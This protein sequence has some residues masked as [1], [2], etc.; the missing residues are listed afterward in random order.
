MLFEVSNIW[1]ICVF[2]LSSFKKIVIF[3]IIRSLKGT[4]IKTL[5]SDFL[6]EVT[7]LVQLYVVFDYS[8]T[9]ITSF[10]ELSSNGLQTLP[11]NIFNHVTLLRS[12]FVSLYSYHSFSSSLSRDI[13]DN[14]LISLPST[15]FSSLRNLNGLKVKWCCFY[16]QSFDSSKIC[17]PINFHPSLQRCLTIS[18]MLKLSLNITAFCLLRYFFIIDLSSN[19]LTQFP[20]GLVSKLNNLKYLFVLLCWSQRLS[21][22][23]FRNLE[24]NDLIFLDLETTVPS[25]L[26]VPIHIKWLAP[27]LKDLFFT[28]IFR[29]TALCLLFMTILLSIMQVLQW[30]CLFLLCLF[31]TFIL[32]RLKEFGW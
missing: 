3:L 21:L 7:N 20:S 29:T 26:F 10:L 11:S 22:I 24:S 25:L 13:G 15:I 8:I 1:S 16:L 17:L 31:F 30:N 28:E 6:K 4:G 18:S 19:K 14:S 23:F 32:Y 12:L 9:L 27:L 5:S 2:Y